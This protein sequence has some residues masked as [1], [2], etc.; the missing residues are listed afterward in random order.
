MFIFSTDEFIRKTDIYVDL[1]EAIASQ[2]EANQELYIT[3][4]HSKK[5]REIRQIE[6]LKWKELL[7]N[8]PINPPKRCDWTIKM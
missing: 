3:F 5:T 8:V 4:D 7:H 1:W 2:V 6:I